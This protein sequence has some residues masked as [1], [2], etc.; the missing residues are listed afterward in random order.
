[1]IA[2]SAI[3]GQML[4]HF[5]EAFQPFNYFTMS[6]LINDNYIILPYS[7][8]NG[9]DDNLQIPLS[10]IQVPVSGYAP[11]GTYLGIFQNDESSI[12]PTEGNLVNYVK[13]LLWAEEIFIPGWF[14]EWNNTTYRI[15]SSNDWPYYAG[16]TQYSLERIIGS[17]GQ[18][19]IP[20]GLSD[21]AGNFE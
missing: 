19:T 20:S 3:N 18:G 12:R 4:L 21:G 7:G 6:P 10:G 1:M 17:D 15:V 16:F 8:Y 5:P 2:N 14:V 13:Y 11:P 9:V